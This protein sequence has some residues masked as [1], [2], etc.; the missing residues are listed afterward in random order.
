MGCPAEG[1][2]SRVHDGCGKVR[3]TRVRFTTENSKRSLLRVS[4]PTSR[5]RNFRPPGPGQGAP[6]VVGGFGVK[7]VD[8]ESTTVH[9]HSPGTGTTKSDA[10]EVRTSVVG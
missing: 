8:T 1:T 2:R 9:R 4:H 7:G 10:D 5:D 6:L 3:G